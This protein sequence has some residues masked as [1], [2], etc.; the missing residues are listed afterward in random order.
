MIC[1]QYDELVGKQLLHDI[2]DTRGVLLIPI[3]TILTDAHIE[4]LQQ[5]RIDVMDIHVE[6]LDWPAD[7]APSRESEERKWV[8][9]TES[10]LKEIET[11]IEKNGKV[12][13]EEIE[14]T[15][16]PVILNVSGQSNIYKLFTQLKAGADYRYNHSIGVAIMATTI[17]R[18]MKLDEP[19]LHLLT[20]AASL[21]DIGMIKL[22]SGLLQK[23]TGLMPHEYEIMKQH[24]VMGHQ[25]LLDS[26]VD[27][28]VALIALQH[29]EREDGSGY[30][31][32][33]TGSQLDPLS[34]IVGLADMYMAMT[35]ERPHRAA[36]PFYQVVTQLFD[37]ITLGRLESNLGLTFL[38]RLMSAQIGSDIILS[39]GRR[40]RIVLNNTNY[41][42]RPFIKV[43]NE[44][45]DLSKTGAVRIKEIVG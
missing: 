30:P 14:R 33:L 2:L 9:H 35:T 34:R 43:G 42:N 45:I 26:G 22:P 29:H 44:F 23:T 19:E 36:M 17:G 27:S 28:R 40:G 7:Q 16:L 18:W 10:K 1:A 20:T 39:D 37:E 3:E 25:L 38:S 8:H 6:E 41:P 15:I 32:R 11:F 13:T 4:K 24:T 12:P 31:N 21:C 5:F